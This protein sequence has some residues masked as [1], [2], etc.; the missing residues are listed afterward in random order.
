[1]GDFLD[2]KQLFNH[3]WGES[4]SVLCLNGKLGS[5]GGTNQSM[6]SFFPETAASF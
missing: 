4:F 2:D 6:N 3:T 1:M 5:F